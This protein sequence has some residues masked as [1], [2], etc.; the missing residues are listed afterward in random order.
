M[1]SSIFKLGLILI[2]FI[3]C[4][5]LN[6]DN[7]K[8]ISFANLSYA[9]RVALMEEH[10]TKDSILSSDQEFINNEILNRRF[11]IDLS[12]YINRDCIPTRLSKEELIKK[13][14][15]FQNIGDIDRDKKDDF[16]FVLSP[17]DFCEEGQSYYFSNPD[18]P[19]IFS[20]S[21]CCHPNSIFSIGDI[22]EDGS[23]EIAQ[24]FS[25]CASRYKKIIIWTLKGNKWESIDEFTFTLNDKFEIF[26]D[27]DKLSSKVS[28]GVFKFL[29]I[30]DI[31]A[32]GNLIS[33]WKTIKM[34]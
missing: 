23:N 34:N 5:E 10:T 1:K 33:E 29:E 30:S 17:L 8:Q 4:K 14:E 32:N 3:S 12:K 25:S 7:S 22:D 31:D 16:V 20:D 27:F 15:G 9:E 11:K 2:I 26:E 6:T 24:Y 18:I 21:Y 19:R 13:F 28:K